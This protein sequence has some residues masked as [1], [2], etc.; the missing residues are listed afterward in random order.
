MDAAVPRAQKGDIDAFSLIY[1]QFSKPMFGICLRIMGNRNDAEDVLQ[2]VFIQAFGKIKELR[3]PQ[4]FPAWMRQ[5]TVRECLAKL[6]K[7]NK[8]DFVQDDILEVAEEKE[9][10]NWYE[11]I[12]IE[13]LQH[14]IQNL[15]NGCRQIF[16]LYATEN[17]THKEIAE[18][19]NISEG[20]SKSQYSRAR[21]LLKEH[22]TK[23]IING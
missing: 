4:L 14:S 3:Q 9:D 22:L 5:V 17:Y 7:N 23:Q 12:S 21:N 18:S 15:P 19:L 1:R 10:A 16:V 11:N 13:K 2:D 6:K 20:T 8:I